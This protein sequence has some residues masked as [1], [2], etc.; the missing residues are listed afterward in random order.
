ME[1]IILTDN[2]VSEVIDFINRLSEFL[3][4]TDRNYLQVF[5][6]D[7][8]KTLIEIYRRSGNYD[9][10]SMSF[11]VGSIF[12]RN[13]LGDYVFVNSDGYI[14]GDSKIGMIQSLFESYNKSDAPIKTEFTIDEYKTICR[15]LGETQENIT[16][17]SS[18]EIINRLERL[19]YPE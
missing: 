18:T 16:V 1:K 11:G 9:I 6:L 8:N 2:N 17:K 4:K 19:I 3:V 5:Q 15:I 13:S 7:T 12:T 14:Y 10:D